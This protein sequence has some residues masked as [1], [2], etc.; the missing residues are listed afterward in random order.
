MTG[1]DQVD[2]FSAL[3][4]P[5]SVTD[6]EQ[7]IPGECWKVLLVDDEPDIHA[8]FRLALQGI[9]VYGKQVSL[10]T[11]T[12]ALDAREVLKQ[13]P[14]IAL[15]LLD[16]V[17][18]N[19]R[20]GLD[21]AQEIRQHIHNQL[22]QI[23]LVTG[24]PGYAPQ[25][26]VVIDHEINGYLLKSELTVDKVFL[27]LHTALRAYQTLQQKDHLLSEE[28][29][30]RLAMDLAPSYI[31]LKDKASCYVYANAPALKLFDCSADE[32]IGK[33]DTNFFPADTVTRLR[34]IDQRVFNGESTNEELDITFASGERRVY[35]EV[36]APVY[37]TEG[38]A[39]I[40]GLVGISTDITD[41]KQL[42]EKLVE[43]QKNLEAK[44]AARA[45]QLVQVN[46]KLRDT[47]FAMDKAG[48]G[49]AWNDTRTGHFLYVNDE[50]C[51]QL[52]YSA[53]ELL[54]LTVSDINPEYSPDMV[55]QIAQDLIETGK[56]KRFETSHRRKDGSLFP[57]EVTLYVLAHQKPNCYV[58]FYNDITQRK[59]NE[60][61]LIQARNA[62][63][64]AN[65]AKTTFLANMSHELRTP[66]NAILG[67]SQLITHDPDISTA[68]LEK[69][70]IINRSGEHL[71]MLINNVL[72]IAKI[73][74]G[75]MQLQ[76]APLELDDMARSAV[77][78]FQVRAQ[79]KG[80]QLS[81]E[82]SPQLPRSIVADEA[83]LRQILINLIGNAVKFTPAA[84]KVS[85]RL[86]VSLHAESAYLKI[87]VEDT[88]P[89]I[90]PEEHQR[91]FE[92]FMQT[93]D[94]QAGQGT[95]LGLAI[96][97]DFITLMGG[98]ICLESAPGQGALFRVELPLH[99]ALDTALV[100]TQAGVEDDVIG[101]APDQPDYR[102]LI[103]EDQADNRMLLHE[104]MR[105][106]GLQTQLATNGQEA[107]ELFKTG[108]PHLI[109]M[110][111]HM[112]VMDG[113][114]ATRIIRQLPGGQA[115]KIVAVTT[116]VFK[117]LRHEL[118]QTGF[119]EVIDK[120]Y[121]ANQIYSCLA[122]LL[123][124]KFV[125]LNKI[126]PDAL[127]RILTPDLFAELPESLLGEL[128]SALELLDI[129][130]IDSVIAKVAPFNPKLHALL[131]VLARRFDYAAIQEQIEAFLR[132]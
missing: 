95:G 2:S 86:G 115:V 44:V 114:E 92:P 126:Q 57:V 112:P 75:R 4:A 69:L 99:E 116:A 117:E 39:E 20:A 45:A 76:N 42:E 93:T 59:Q 104:L 107:V 53:E 29:H 130:Q 119:D 14:D 111:R 47:L 80:L 87:E 11:A 74:V 131:E 77:A 85:V 78:L 109:W 121:R 124:V 23:I 18:E 58:A 81:L 70:H 25:R 71:L 91:I 37:E 60:A 48:I 5:E 64:S 97:R 22:I 106:L 72:E 108:Q 51:R 21:L 68:V 35:W 101:L 40:W 84:G 54:Q 13:H 94:N 16:V 38:Q 113:D 52:G 123:R 102:I 88:G 1:S 61:D 41:R 31:Y 15:M 27:N 50:A 132:C 33:D 28:A 32:L 34:E 55:A 128:K 46:E 100:P 63:E 30:F 49:I 79:E 83:R 110:D 98:S 65:R 82:L 125:Y 12:S 90:S 89:G 3:F 66:L 122:D 24:Q 103:A 127:P 67:F 43:H 9:S 7:V 8:F 62:A 129:D 73:E 17:M 36:K 56:S 96:S 120:P 118:L 6:S 26:Q 105:K 10:L 19:D